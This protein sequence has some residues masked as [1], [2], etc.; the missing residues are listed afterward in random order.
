MEF[1][2][3][4]K[5]RAA[6]NLGN[7]LLASL[8]EGSAAPVGVSVDLAGELARRLGV[9]LELVLFEAAGKAADALARGQ[10]NI[11]FVA[12]DPQ[13]GEGIRFSAPYLQIEGSYLVRADSPILSNDD[14]DRPG[15]QV[16]VGL[17]SAYDLQLSRTLKHAQVVRA[18]TSPAVVDTFMREGHEVAAGVRQQ[19]EHD[20]RRFDGLRLLG[21]RFMT[22]NQA[23]GIPRHYS[24]DALRL[25]RAFVE[26]MKSSGFVAD[27]LARHH[28]AGAAVAP[29]AP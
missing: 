4:G 10:V 9:E 12:V 16:T 22:I 19:L 5:L 25:L 20:A 13:R 27:A 26:D 18:T 1:L 29:P 6:I 3:K 14:V 8:P 15:I 28:I 11:G 21:G 7:P 2:T 23:M 24:D 17:G